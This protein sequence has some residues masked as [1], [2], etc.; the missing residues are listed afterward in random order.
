MVSEWQHWKICLRA[1]CIDAV[2]VGSILRAEGQTI[3]QAAADYLQ[4]WLD[5]NPAPLYEAV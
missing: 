4:M 3:S 1:A 5:K 2:V